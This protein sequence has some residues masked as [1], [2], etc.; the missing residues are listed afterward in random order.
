M[1]KVASLAVK[2]T[3][4]SRYKFGKSTVTHYC[5][6]TTNSGKM[7]VPHADM[8]ATILFFKED[9]AKERSGSKKKH[10]KQK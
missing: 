5:I 9:L 4:F 3:I 8:I 2:M 6:S 1:H 7:Q 10:R